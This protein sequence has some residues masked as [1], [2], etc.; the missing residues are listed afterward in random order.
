VSLVLALSGGVGGAKLALGLSRV[1]PAEELLVVANTGDDFEHLG[2]TICPDIDTLTYALAG[3]DN[4]ATGWGRRDETWNF[5]AALAELGGETWFRLGDQDLATHVE[6]TRRLAAGE[7]LSQVTDDHRRRLGIGARILPMSD[8][9]VR[10]RVRTEERGWLDFQDYFVRRQAG[11]TVRELDFAG[12]AAARANPGLLAALADPAL[13]CVVI[14]PSN[15]FI[16]VGPIL[17]VPGV[18]AALEACP[19]P[20]VAISPIIGGAAVK[21]PTA[22]MF[23]ELGLGTP[24][25]AGVAAHYGALLDGYVMDAV[26]A[27][28]ASRIRGPRVALAQ[29]LMKTLDDR[30]ALA[31]AVLGFADS[32]RA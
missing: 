31:N 8:D 2:L 1:L 21:G 7:T 10:T 29:T 20:V 13:R 11:P 23:A 19:A 17:A 4:P 27:E 15:P 28:E 9:P 25:A 32:L 18:R 3:V 5:M 16:S 22:K 6:R 30:E 26:D 24:T 14:C 12:A